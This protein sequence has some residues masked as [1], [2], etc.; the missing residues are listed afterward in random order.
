MILTKYNP[1]NFSENMLALDAAFPSKDGKISID[2]MM[3]SAV[4]GATS[5]P[6]A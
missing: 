3:R 1:L 4:G 5:A 2:W 6:A